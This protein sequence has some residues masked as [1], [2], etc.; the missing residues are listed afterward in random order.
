LSLASARTYGIAGA[1]FTAIA[2]ILL[3]FVF[4]NGQQDSTFNAQL[5]YD[6]LTG[7]LAAIGFFSILSSVEKISKALVERSIVD[8]FV[9]AVAFGAAT[10][11]VMVTLSV[12]SSASIYLIGHGFNLFLPTPA[13]ASAYLILIPLATIEGILFMRCFLTM[14]R[15]LHGN[16]FKVV[17]VFY[18]IAGPS[19]VVVGPLLFDVAPFLLIAAF[20][21]IGTQPPPPQKTWDDV[22]K[23]LVAKP[24]VSYSQFWFVEDGIARVR[25]V[26]GNIALVFF[27]LVFAWSI[28]VGYIVNPPP[29]PALPPPRE[30]EFTAIG[31]F[32][33]LLSFVVISR[34]RYPHLSVQ[35]ALQHKVELASWD[36]VSK[37]TLIGMS[38]RIVIGANE[39]SNI[40][41]KRYVEQLT[42]LLRSKLGD[43]FSVSY[44]S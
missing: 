35:D 9:L 37:A 17:G 1:S 41:P 27:V 15:Q 38:F 40:V 5:L 32:V 44:R 18:L 20:L 30:Y 6:G 11:G 33:M 8:Y 13:N 23:I 4:P 3:V 22:P 31:N 14:S 29:A 25:P 2:V 12:R 42:E 39:F 24:L 34:V 7:L 26:L 21:R 10:G 28:I 16:L 36:S 19:N 43:R